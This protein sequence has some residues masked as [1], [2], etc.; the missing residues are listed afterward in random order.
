M[1]TTRN[2]YTHM[3]V[4]VCIMC[5]IYIYIYTEWRENYVRSD[6]LINSVRPPSPVCGD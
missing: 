6:G 5:T 4:C 2:S 1:T 3:Y